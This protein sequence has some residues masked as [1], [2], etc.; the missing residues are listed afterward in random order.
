MRPNMEGV[1]IG[2]PC[3]DWHQRDRRAIKRCKHSKKV[4]DHLIGSDGLR[5]QVR[6]VPNTGIKMY[7]ALTYNTRGF[8]SHSLQGSQRVPLGLAVPWC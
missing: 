8:D 5:A 4:Q 2:V 3:H 7:W 1:E 6:G